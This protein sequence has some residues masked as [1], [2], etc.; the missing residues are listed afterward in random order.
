L[1]DNGFA[2]IAMGKSNECLSEE[3]RIYRF[4]SVG[5]LLWTKLFTEFPECN[6]GY[7]PNTILQTEDL[8]F[9]IGGYCDHYEWNISTSSWDYSQRI[10]LI[11]TDS[12]GN[13][14]VLSNISPY[15]ANP[16]TKFDLVCYPNPASSEFFVDL[17]QGIEDDVLEIYSTSG[18][19]VHE[20][21]VG[22]YNNRVDICN[23]KQGMY[24]VRL[25]GKGLFGKII[26]E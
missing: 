2:G 6:I 12:L 25:R 3:F 14:T 9:A 15:Q 20:Q 16:I 13:D 8:G 5:I 22:K 10:F 21:A 7:H 26:V 18:A 11:K 24:L 19:L 1:N 23:L 17:P 4:D